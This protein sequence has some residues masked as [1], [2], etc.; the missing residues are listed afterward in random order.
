MTPDERDRLA[1]LEQ[2]MADTREDMREIK[3]DVKLILAQ[4]NNSKGRAS[5]AALILMAGGGFLTWLGDHIVVPLLGK[6]P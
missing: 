6:H 1:R 4:L 3:G 2:Q 5:M